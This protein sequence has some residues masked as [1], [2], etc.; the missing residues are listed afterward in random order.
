MLGYVICEKPEMKVKEYELYN[1]Y[2]CGVCKSVGSRYGHVPRAMLSYDSAFLAVLLAGMDD[3]SDT[4]KREHCIAHRFQKKTIVKNRYVDYAAD[5]MLMLAYMNMQDD[6][7]DDNS[8]KAKVGKMVLSKYFSTVQRLHPDLTLEIE[9]LL[10]E[11]AFLESHKCSSLDQ[12]SDC[13]GR[14]LETILAGGAYNCGDGQIRVLKRFGY[15]LGKWIYLVDAFDD[16]AEDIINDSFNPLLYRYG[17]Y[18]RAHE[19]AA[20]FITRIKPECEQNMLILCAEMSKMLDLLDI[21]KN[22]AIIEN[23]VR[24][25]LLRSTDNVLGNTTLEGEE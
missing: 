10:K 11:L 7:D 17:Y 2:Y 18:E 22:N 5:I 15:H 25:G 19:T 13:F 23:I 21:K 12:V 24:M 4:V 16:V 20:E 3:S 9:S 8:A 1:G 6:I 14:I